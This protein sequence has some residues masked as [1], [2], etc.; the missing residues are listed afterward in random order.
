[1]NSKAVSVTT[2]PGDDGAQT[3]AN[4]FVRL[5]S[6]GAATYLSYWTLFFAVQRACSHLK[7]RSGAA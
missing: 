3:G 5:A 4:R 2:R 1:M 6:V 7:D